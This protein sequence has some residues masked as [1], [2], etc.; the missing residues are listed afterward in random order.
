MITIESGFYGVPFPEITCSKSRDRGESPAEW[1]VF[2]L[3]PSPS[4]TDPRAGWENPS[5]L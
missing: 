4:L 5:S 2:H 1:H 3:D